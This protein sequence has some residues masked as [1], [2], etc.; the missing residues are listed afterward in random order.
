MLEKEI[1][2]KVNDYAKSTG[3]LQYKFVSPGMAGVPDRLYFLCG[4]CLA[5]E[6]KAL[7]KKATKLQLKELRK[8]RLA[9]IDCAVIDNVTEA[10]GLLDQLREKW[11]LNWT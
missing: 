5:I 11:D 6:F 10:K 3:W 2:K 1:E 7:G 8:L 9:G 4:H